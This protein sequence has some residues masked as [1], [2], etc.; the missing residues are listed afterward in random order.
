MTQRETE[1]QK[2]H[3]LVIGARESAEIGGV[4]EVE[5]FDEQAVVL[6]TDCGELTLEGEGLHVGTL[7]IA[8]GIVAVSGQINALYYS[9][10]APQRRGLRSRLFG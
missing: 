2:K 3:T 7:D 4:C 10:G 9:N 5:S 6:K 8:R 1:N